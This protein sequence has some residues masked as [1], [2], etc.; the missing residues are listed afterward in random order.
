MMHCAPQP[1]R[2]P[3]AYAINPHNPLIHYVLRYKQEETMNGKVS[4]VNQD[5]ALILSYETGKY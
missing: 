4:R 3:Y 2:S 5:R 1:C